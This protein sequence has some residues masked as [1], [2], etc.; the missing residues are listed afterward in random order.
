MTANNAHVK[1]V[2][3]KY[4]RLTNDKT[5]LYLQSV[6]PKDHA[7]KENNLIQDDLEYV[8]SMLQDTNVRSVAD[9]TGLNYR[10]VWSIKNG[11]N[12]CPHFQTVRKLAEYF[13]EKAGQ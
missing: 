13:R 5:A 8:V 9:K 4:V 3:H 7:F 1:P 2:M 11:S 12:K 6:D 10:T